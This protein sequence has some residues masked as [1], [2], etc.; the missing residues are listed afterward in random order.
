MNDNDTVAIA[1]KRDLLCY[2]VASRVAG[3]N[4]IASNPGRS[5]AFCEFDLPENGRSVFEESA[6]CIGGKIYCF[7]PELGQRLH[8]RRAVLV[9]HHDFEMGEGSIASV[10]DTIPVLVEHRLECG[11]IIACCRIPFREHELPRLDD[12]VQIV[13]IIKQY[14]IACSGPGQSILQTVIIGVHEKHRLTEFGYR[15]PISV[16]I[17]QNRKQCIP[18]FIFSTIA[19]YIP[20]RIASDISHLVSIVVPHSRP[21]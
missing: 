8:V 18:R 13:G 7:D 21:T 15:N 9:G 4:N 6:V 20:L 19:A 10:E 2:T 3:K 11:Q 17:K 5:I 14:A 12:G 1:I 16:Q